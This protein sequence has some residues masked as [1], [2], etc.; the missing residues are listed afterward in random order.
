MMRPDRVV[1]LAMLAFAVGYGALAWQYPLLPFERAMPFK[2]NTL[3][4]GLAVAAAVLSFAVLIFPGGD[5]KNEENK[6]WR[7]LD[8]RR[9]VIVFVLALLYA[10]TLRPLGFVLSTTL[11]L[12]A[13]AFV[14]GERRVK[15]LAS[16]PLVASML[17]WYLVQELLGVYLKPLPV[18]LS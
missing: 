5:G 17:S 15:L 18:F 13:G 1:A 10:A 8:W 11:F 2:P 12:S 9:A 14:L 6:D 7:G 16:V 3:P 4:K